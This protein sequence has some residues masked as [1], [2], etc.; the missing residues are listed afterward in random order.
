MEE[1]QGA[2]F[3]LAFVY[4]ALPESPLSSRLAIDGRSQVLRRFVKWQRR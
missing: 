4:V 2:M 3:S 1:L